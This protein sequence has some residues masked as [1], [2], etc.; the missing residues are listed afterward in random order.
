[1][2]GTTPL[3][4]EQMAINSMGLPITVETFISEM[5]KYKY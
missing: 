5:K 2:M 4:G 3:V 1:M